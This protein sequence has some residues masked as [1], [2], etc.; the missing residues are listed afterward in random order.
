LLFVTEEEAYWLITAVC[1]HGLP[2]YYSF[3]MSG[4]N[5]DQQLFETIIAERMPELS[6]HLLEIGVPIAIVTIPWFLCL[7]VGFLPWHV[8][9]SS[10][11]S[12]IRLAAIPR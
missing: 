12:S 11:S 6:E 7:Y 9:N 3:S 4:A 5:A 1:E 2:D 10:S 8:R